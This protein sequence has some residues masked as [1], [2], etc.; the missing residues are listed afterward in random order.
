LA[1]S[2]K[3]ITLRLLGNTTKICFAKPHEKRELQET[4]V[5]ALILLGFG[6]SNG[7]C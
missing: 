6:E 2:G 1:L 4:I 7:I 5:V 3:F